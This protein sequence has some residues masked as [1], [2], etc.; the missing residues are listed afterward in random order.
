MPVINSTKDL[1]IKLSK[2][3]ELVGYKEQMASTFGRDTSIIMKRS[4]DQMIRDLGRL[5]EDKTVKV[6]DQT[7]AYIAGGLQ[8]LNSLAL[9]SPIDSFFKRFCEEYLPLANNW[10]TAFLQSK[11]IEVKIKSI[12]RIV[13]DHLTISELTV[14]A[15][16]LIKKLERETHY[17]LPS[18]EASGAFLKSMDEEIKR[19]KEN[20]EI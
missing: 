12:D 2:L 5:S 9:S 13:Q 19:M 7:K 4:A 20:G 1:K 10:N 14:V 16:G 3:L 18:F 15:R 17:R 11:N 8:R 6:T